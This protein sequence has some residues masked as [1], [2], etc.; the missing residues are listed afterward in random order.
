MSVSE[1]VR[2]YGPLVGFLGVGTT[3]WVN[4]VRAELTRRREMHARAIEAVVAYLQMP[5]AIRRRRHEHQHRSA[6][7]VRLSD[8]FSAVQAELATC[9][10]LMR[11]DVDSLVRDGYAALVA[12]LREH[13]GEQAKSAWRTPPIESDCEMGMGDVHDALRRVR[14]QQRS[15]ERTTA[16][17][18][19]PW[20]RKVLR[21]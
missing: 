3:L 11:T 18:T 8:A 14:E 12:T 13:A 19:Q 7:R 17:A 9:E 15:F 5:Y 4:G 21:S 6:E 16:R 10:A 20:Y 2:D 1:V